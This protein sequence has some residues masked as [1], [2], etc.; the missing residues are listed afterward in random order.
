MNICDAIDGTIIM[1]P[2]IVNAI[3]SMYQFRVPHKW[4]YDPTGAEISW[5][6]PSLGGWLTSLKNRYFQLNSWYANNQRPPSFWLSGFFNPEGFLTAVKQEICRSTGQRGGNQWS[7]EN[8]SYKIEVKSNETIE[9]ADGRVDRPIQPPQEGVYIHGLSLEGAGWDK[10]QNRLCESTPKQ[11]FFT[12]PIIHV[13]ATG[14][15]E[16]NA[17][18]GIKKADDKNSDKGMYSCPVYKYP[19]RNDKYI[20]S[21]F[22]LRGEAAQGNQANAYM[23]KGMRSET[24]WKLKGVTLLCQRD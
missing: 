4:V 20:I 17:L 8:V 23:P 13:S 11:L 24:N 14:P 5:L 18:G 21:R 2:E 16:A 15:Q 9:N 7:L 3:E 19:R 6:V 1:T 10:K 12:F 22:L